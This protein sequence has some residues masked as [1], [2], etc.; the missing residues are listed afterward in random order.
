MSDFLAH[1]EAR[2]S[3]SAE[4]I[5]PRVAS[6]FEPLPSPIAPP[7]PRGFPPSEPLGEHAMF[8]EN[9]ARRSFEPSSSPIAGLPNAHTD[10]RW[11]DF[12]PQGPLAAQDR[13]SRP[14]IPLVAQAA[15]LSDAPLA[16]TPRPRPAGHVVRVSAT[17]PAESLGDRAAINLQTS[18]PEHDRKR[19]TDDIL[20][21]QSHEP[22]PKAH[23]EPNRGLE[24]E[25]PPPV[26]PKPKTAEAVLQPHVKA[27]PEL[28]FPWVKQ[29]R[30]A[31]DR[32]P[33]IQVTI[34]RIEVRAT[35]APAQASGR[36]RSQPRVMSLD[37]YL[38]R[39]RGRHDAGGGE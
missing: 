29:T 13:M 20:E 27:M 9:Q 26:R 18:E 1:L 31:E 11:S 22:E 4:V 37:E 32:E 19:P 3:G 21:H 23:P 34:G 28:A 39:R 2:S 16:E 10:S 33:T 15:S 8:E 36:E 24:P 12:R 30:P 17:L 35:P 7:G 14:G 5:R 6:I 38:R 25:P